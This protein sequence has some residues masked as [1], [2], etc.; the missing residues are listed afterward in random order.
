[1]STSPRNPV[2]VNQDITGRVDTNDYKTPAYAATI[3]ITTR[4]KRTLVQPGQLTG[5][6]TVNVGVGSASSAPFVGDELKFMFAGDAS[7]RTVTFGTGLTV[8]SATLALSAGKKG[9][10]EFIFDGA[11]WI[12]VSRVIHA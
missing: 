8:A 12:E 7:A 3:N 1:M 2:G 9:Y 11:A 10:I 6:L 5:A 4:Q